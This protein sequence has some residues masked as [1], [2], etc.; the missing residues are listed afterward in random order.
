MKI[1]EKLNNFYASAIEVANKESDDTIREFTES[2]N[3]N[4]EEFRRQKEEETE[5]TFGVEAEKLKR[6]VNRRISE[7][8][9]E[10][11]QS[12]NRLQQKK[13]EEL[14]RKVY[15]MLMEYRNTT[16]YENYLMKS[17]KK[18]EK[19]AKE[20]AMVIYL[21]P[22]DASKKE[23]LERE[24]GY[25]LTVSKTNFGG[26]IRAIIRTRNIVIDE[27]FETKLRQEWDT[28]SF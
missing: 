13:K 28:Y 10:K 4:L 26:G 17:I 3:R 25:G 7:A 21:D 20:E 9:M 22:A 14:F 23:K 11:K 12:L 27:T 2:M 6:D 1:T 24:T 8:T 19:F 5:I 16:D 15:E 18:A